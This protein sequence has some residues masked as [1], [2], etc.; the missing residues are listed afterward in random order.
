MRPHLATLLDDFRRHGD[1]RAIVTHA[2]NRRYSSTWGEL[3]DPRF[4]NKLTFA[5]PRVSGTGSAVVSALVSL[6]ILRAQGYDL[7]GKLAISFGPDPPL[8]FHPAAIRVSAGFTPSGAGENP[9]L[10]L[11]RRTQVGGVSR[12]HQLIVGE[13]ERLSA[14]SESAAARSSLRSGRAGRGRRSALLRSS[15]RRQYRQ[16]R[17]AACDYHGLCLGH[18]VPLSCVSETGYSAQIPEWLTVVGA[19]VS[20]LGLAA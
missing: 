18:G 12:Y 4:R 14:A 1:Q 19:P 10:S 13:I 11:N 7:H 20:Q 17:Q 9:T 8:N 2:G 5:N 6:L 3:A 15:K 16:Q